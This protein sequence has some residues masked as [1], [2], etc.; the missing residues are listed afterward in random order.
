VAGE[1]GPPGP[2]LRCV[3]GRRAGTLPGFEFSPAL[4][5]AA[6][7]GHVWTRATLDAFLIDPEGVLPGTSMTM[8]GLPDASDRDDVIDFLEAAGRGCLGSDSDFPTV[9]DTV[10]HQTSGRQ[11]LT[12]SPRIA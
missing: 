12:E 2:N 6:R 7:R 10:R 9:P 5:A 11:R 1:D 3:I 4:T 8:P